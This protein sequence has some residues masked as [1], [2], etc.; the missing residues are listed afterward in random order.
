MISETLDEKLSKSTLFLEI[1]PNV[2][3]CLLRGIKGPSAHHMHPWQAIAALLFETSP[4][5]ASYL[6]RQLVG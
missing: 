4:V 5:Q 2:T 1:T 6:A 3:N